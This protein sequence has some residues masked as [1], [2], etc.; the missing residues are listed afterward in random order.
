LK[1]S[2]TEKT[3]EHQD[4]EDNFR[5]QSI[6]LKSAILNP[7]VLSPQLAGLVL[8]LSMFLPLCEGCDGKNVY[9]SDMLRASPPSPLIDRALIASHFGFGL[10][11]GASLAVVGIFRSRRFFIGLFFA[12]LSSILA[13]IAVVFLPEFFDYN[14]KD[15]VGNFLAIAPPV[16]ACVTWVGFA[17]KRRRWPEAWG[18]LNIGC[19]MYLLLWIHM[20]CLFARML[21][22][23][24]FV[25]LIGIILLICSIVWCVQ[26]MEHDLWDRNQPK[27]KLQFSV[28][29]IMAWTTGLAVTIGYYRSLDHVLRWLFN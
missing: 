13:L 11:L 18:R 27:S 14:L 12:E 2:S 20:L 15:M 21:L 9:P 1:E 5:P 10:L 25:F 7:T 29:K 23:G 6:S 28:A 16:V 3:P 4:V 26:R 8:L 24:Y 17:I 19:C 22:V